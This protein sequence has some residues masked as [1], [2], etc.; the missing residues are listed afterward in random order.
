[1]QKQ[2]KKSDLKWMVNKLF[3]WHLL[4]RVNQVAKSDKKNLKIWKCEEE[5]DDVDEEEQ[6][7]VHFRIGLMLLIFSTHF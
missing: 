2:Q 5:E 3:L 1:M 4:K 6:E 7:I